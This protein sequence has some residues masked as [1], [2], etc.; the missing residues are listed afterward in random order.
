MLISSADIERAFH[1]VKAVR[2]YMKLY[3]VDGESH[4]LSV[5]TLRSS[6]ADMYGLDIELYEVITS[7]RRVLGNVERYTDGKAIIL[8]KSQLDDAT[9]RFVAVKELCHLMIDEQD[10]WSSS[11]ATTL[12]EMKVEFDSIK[13]NGEGVGNPSRSQVSE[14]LAWFAA[15]ALMYPCEFHAADKARVD[16]EETTVARLALY[17]DMPG[18]AL[19]AAFTNR[20]IFEIY[21]CAGDT[22]TNEASAA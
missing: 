15:I 8:V 12:R 7:S 5:D 22:A 20:D 3:H 10:D 11:G 19:E 1:K 16:N 2:D 18:A 6:V 4:R 17:H 9:K 13:K 21:P 14:V